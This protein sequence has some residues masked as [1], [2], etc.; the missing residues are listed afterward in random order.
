MHKKKRHILGILGGM[1]PEATSVLYAR[2][3]RHTVA[4]KD[5]D[6]LDIWIDSHAGLPDRTASILAGEEEK[7]KSLLREDARKLAGLGC[8]YLAVPCNTSHFF[9]EVFREIPGIT[10]IDMIV[11]TAGYVAGRGW[12]KVGILATDGTV[13][14]GLYEKALNEKGVTALY[15]DEADQKAVMKLIYEEIKRGEMGTLSH[16]APVIQHM[17]QMGCEAVVLACT[18]LSVFAENYRLTDSF[19]VD[20]MGVLAE[21]CITLCGGSYRD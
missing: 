13:K 17:K 5:Q 14:G 8:D 9:R 4:R 3:I 11:E 6:H 18:E 7:M 10:F 12:K 16:F 19:Y 21:R 1:G 20:A 2:I 15:P